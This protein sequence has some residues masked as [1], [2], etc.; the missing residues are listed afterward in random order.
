[1]KY[2]KFKSPWENSGNKRKKSFIENI[3]FYLG[4]SS[5]PDYECH[6]DE[7]ESWM[8]EFDE[9]N[10][11]IR[12]IGIDDKGKVVLKMPYKKNYGY[13]TDNSL[14]YEDFTSSFM[15]VKIRQEEFE[16]KWEEIE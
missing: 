4:L 6:I 11:P 16:E 13:W 9:E 8:V 1:M 10:I 7:V 2:L 5:N 3:V 14:E 15:T 12:E